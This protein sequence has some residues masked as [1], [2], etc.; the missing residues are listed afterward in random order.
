MPS[1]PSPRDR[2]LHRLLWGGVLLIGIAAR[3][4]H[5]FSGLEYDEIWTLE[6]FAPLPLSRILTDLALPNNHPLNTLGVWIC[7]TLFQSP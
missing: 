2:R 3:L 4:T 1:A 7:A 5:L 6:N